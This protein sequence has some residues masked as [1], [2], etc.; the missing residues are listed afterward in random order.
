MVDSQNFV[1]DLQE[2]MF[3]KVGHRGIFLNIR[4]FLSRREIIMRIYEARVI[5][6]YYDLM[7]HGH[8]IIMFHKNHRAYNNNIGTIR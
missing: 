5:I 4:N 1:S 2:E 7:R 8:F 3:Q 6:F